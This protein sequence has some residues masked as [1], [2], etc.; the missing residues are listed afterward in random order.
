MVKVLKELQSR[1]ASSPIFADSGM[2][3]LI[4][5]LQPANAPDPI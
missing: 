3:R 5:D 2:V 4:K 1:N